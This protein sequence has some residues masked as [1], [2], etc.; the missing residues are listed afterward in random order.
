M[1]CRFDQIT[2]RRCGMCLFAEPLDEL[3]AEAALKL[4]NLHADRRLRQMQLAS[5]SGKAPALDHRQERTQ[6]IEVEAAHLKVSIMETITTIN[7]HYSRP[8]RN[9]CAPSRGPRR[10]ARCWAAPGRRHMVRPG[11]AARLQSDGR[12]DAVDGKEP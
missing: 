2:T 11:A 7:L 8:G 3:D 6:L 10:G 4:A 1:L 12:S 9:S 5:G